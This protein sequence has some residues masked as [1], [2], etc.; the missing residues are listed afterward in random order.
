MT[1]H[2]P[3]AFPRVSDSPADEKTVVSAPIFSRAGA[4]PQ[5]RTVDL[6]PQQT[7]AS[8]KSASDSRVRW[9]IVG[10]ATLLVV[11]LIGAFLVFAAPKGGTP[12]T[13]ARYA[14][15]DTVAYFETRVDLPGD[16]HD[17][18]A[19][20]M[21]H[22]PGFADQQAFDQKF[23][24]TF[25]QLLE[26][27]DVGLSWQA[28]IKPWFGGQIGVF[29]STI[30]P[31]PG[32][33]PSM[34][35]VLSVKDSA[36]LDSFLTTHLEPDA[37]SEDYQGQLI[38]TGTPLRVGERMNVA[39]TE[40]ALV[41]GMRIEDVKRALDAHAD[42]QPGLADDQFFLQQLGALHA[43]HLGLVYYDG[44][45]TSAQLHDQMDGLGELTVPS[46]LL[47]W[48]I[49][50]TEARAMGE[51]R[52]EA[53]HLTIT[54]RGD[55]PAN[56]DLPPLPA[57][58]SSALANL[59]PASSV[60]YVEMRDVGQTIGFVLSK[61]LTPTPGAS[62]LPFDLGSFDQMLGTSIPEYFDFLV[63]VGASISV[64]D[65]DA[66]FG[67]V[68]SVDDEAIAKSRVD[69][70]LTLARSLMQFGGDIT[71]EDRDFSGVPATVINFGAGPVGPVGGIAVAVH[72]GTLYIGNEEFV[73]FALDHPAGAALAARP[74]YQQGLQAG[75]SNN[76]GV[77]FVDIT[78][79]RGLAE[80]T[81]S[82]SERADYDLNKRP[83]LTPLSH[84]M[85]V[86]RTDGATSVGHVFLYVE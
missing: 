61:L 10:V 46:G 15:A 76:A 29:S 9:A 37:Q 2:Q 66:L 28:D 65:G 56:A 72:A 55:R 53:D 85:M 74:E 77:A 71:F 50:A 69:R 81:M 73:D 49:S 26:G 45:G 60:A 21:S 5:P 42:R 78:A 36:A 41:V 39:A 33:P 51:L 13:V 70:L 86:N 27:N 44:R 84:L 68:A 14:P 22:F 63:D 58:R 24:E 16:Q 48:V 80:A 59:V 25:H 3:H 79:L 67:L 17:G 30:N 57:N 40:D 11:A 4:D 19:A 7:L 20:F 32:T 64:T 38:W 62:P 23:D 75:G 18:L 82:D 8:P 35:A 1:D 31:E 47:D 34:T 12:S 43:D 83:F 52:A 54:S 6:A